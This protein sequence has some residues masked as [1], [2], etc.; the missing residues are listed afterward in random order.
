MAIDETTQTV[1]WKINPASKSF[2]F[3]NLDCAKYVEMIKFLDYNP[4]KVGKATMMYLEGNDVFKEFLSQS[5]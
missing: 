5:Y 4:L 2:D 1:K 3:R